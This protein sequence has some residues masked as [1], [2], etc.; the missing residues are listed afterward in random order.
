ML[1]AGQDKK[2]FTAAYTCTGHIC[3]CPP[4]PGAI[5]VMG[6]LL[7][8]RRAVKYSIYYTCDVK[9]IARTND[10]AYHESIC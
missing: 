1:D 6:W 2:V 3:E 5:F 10:R 4:P 7:V 8:G 9:D